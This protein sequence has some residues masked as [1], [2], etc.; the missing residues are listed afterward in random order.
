MTEKNENIQEENQEIDSEATESNIEIIDNAQETSEDSD[1]YNDDMTKKIEELNTKLEESE[2]KYLRLLAEY[3]NFRKRTAK[4]KIEAFGNAS[5][6][7]I[8]SILPVMDSFERAVLTECADEAYKNGMDMIFNQFK[9]ALEKLD[10]K[11][12]P[13]LGE[14]FDP[15]IHN[16][17]TKVDNEEFESGKICQVY[18]KGYKIGDRLIRPA[19]VAVVF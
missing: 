9:S 18:Q 6:K 13:A 11:E 17:I 5:A 14:D 2:D 19:M 7:C 8:E 10:I 4:E 12:V 16:A 1:E 15:N 3:D